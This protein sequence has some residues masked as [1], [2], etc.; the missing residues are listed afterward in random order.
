MLNFL[1]LLRMGV[2]ALAIRSCERRLASHDIVN[3]PRE[4]LVK[5]YFIT[6]DV[7]SFVDRVL[8]VMPPDEEKLSECIYDNIQETD[9]H[10]A[11]NPRLTSPFLWAVLF[12]IAALGLPALFLLWVVVLHPGIAVAES[13]HV[14]VA[15][16]VAIAVTCFVYAYAS[17]LFG[18][19]LVRRILTGVVV[20][21][22]IAGAFFLPGQLA[23]LGPLFLGVAICTACAVLV[24]HAYSRF[25][26]KSRQT[27]EKLSVPPHSTLLDSLEKDREKLLAK[28]QKAVQD[29][30]IS[31][32]GVRRGGVPFVKF[33]PIP[34]DPSESIIFPHGHPWALI[35]STATREDVEFPTWERGYFAALWLHTR[36]KKTPFFFPDRFSDVVELLEM[37]QKYNDAVSD[38]MVRH[39]VSTEGKVNFFSWVQ[40]MGYSYVRM[41]AEIE[42]LWRHQ[43]TTTPMHIN[44]ANS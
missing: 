24:G 29:G 2:D 9:L 5:I 20:I 27:R 12:S 17:S 19:K 38:G 13:K 10:E 26:R 40:L 30:E 36:W 37:H 1:G 44:G 31:E 35:P 34:F 22:G 43:A 21:A 7:H 41:Y 18:R 14:I 15:L 3:V 42:R 23:E 32:D 11:N 33:Q 28:C 16:F 8:E 4:L 39:G 25:S 6:G